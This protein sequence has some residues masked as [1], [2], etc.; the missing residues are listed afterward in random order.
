MG[1]FNEGQKKMTPNAEKAALGWHSERTGCSPPCC[2]LSYLLP[3]VENSESLREVREQS[4]QVVWV[5]KGCCNKIP[6]I[7]WFLKAE[8]YHVTVPEAGSL[9][10]VSVGLVGS[11]AG[12]ALGLSP[13][14]GAGRPA[15]LVFLACSCLCLIPWCS[16]VSFC[17]SPLL[18]RRTLFMVDSGSLGRPH[19]SLVTS[20]KTLF[21]NQVTFTGMGG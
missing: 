8:M 6:K 19:L 16:W 5:S 15:L 3:R 1:L 4:L 2:A 20:A 21:P 14:P 12:S 17:V 13:G 9:K 7:E 18:H 11:E 10:S